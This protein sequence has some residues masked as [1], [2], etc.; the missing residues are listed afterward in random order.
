MPLIAPAASAFTVDHHK[1]LLVMYKARSG[2]WLG[3]GPVQCLQ[4]AEETLD[5]AG[6]LVTPDRLG[7][8]YYIGSIGRCD[9]YQTPKA[10]ESYEHN[11]RWV[12][13]RIETKC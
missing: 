13:K 1:G 11:A 4:V 9:F 6:D 12:L 5:R 10:V 7:E 2:N 8:P 3:C